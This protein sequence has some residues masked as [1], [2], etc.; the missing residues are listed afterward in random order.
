MIE[1]YFTVLQ[2]SRVSQAADSS[3]NFSDIAHAHVFAVECA[4]MSYFTTGTGADLWKFHRRLTL[5][6][7]QRMLSVEINTR[8]DASAEKDRG[9]SSP[10]AL[11]PT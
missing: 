6:E 9:N 8:I 2:A 11:F 4:L 3:H 10:Q 1:E 5:L 7:A